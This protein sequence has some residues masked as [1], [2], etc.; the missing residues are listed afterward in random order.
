MLVPVSRHV[1]VARFIC[2]GTFRPRCGQFVPSIFFVVAR[3]G[4]LVGSVVG[5]D[6]CLYAEVLRDSGRVAQL[7]PRVTACLL[8]GVL[9]DPLPGL[10]RGEVLA[11]CPRGHGAVVGEGIAARPD[12]PARAA[13]AAPERGK[14]SLGTVGEG[15]VSESFPWAL[16]HRT[17]PLQPP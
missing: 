12:K 10:E 17:P 9:G 8:A 16:S 5:P 3:I 11:E 15:R 13:S 7:P 4:S 2:A 1:C 6:R 14:D